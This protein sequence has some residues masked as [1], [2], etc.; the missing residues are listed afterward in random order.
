MEVQ[1]EDEQQFL[2]R[3][4]QILMQGQSQTRGD[5]PMRTPPQ[6]ARSVSRATV[7]E[8]VL[9][10]SEKLRTIQLN[11]IELNVSRF[12]YVLRWIQG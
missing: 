1:T 12:C 3:Q 2:A 4:Q 6:A 5:S 9:F 10:Y 11:R 7:S 8:M